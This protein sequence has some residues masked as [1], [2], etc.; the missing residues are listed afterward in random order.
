MTGSLILACLWGLVANVAALGPRRM[1]WPAAWALIAAGVPILGWVTYQNGPWVGLVVLAG[2]LS[3]L[4]WP[5]RHAL[6]RL[7]R[8]PAD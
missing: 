7:R 3:V 6:A 5:V 1:H 2:G 4:R 8:R